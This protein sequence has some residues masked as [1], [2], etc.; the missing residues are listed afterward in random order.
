LFEQNKKIGRKL[1]TTGGGRM[2]VNNQ[3]FS[4]NEFSSEQPNLL[5]RLFKNPHFTQRDKIFAEL[6]VE[7]NWEK[8]RAIL[9]SNDARA[10]VERLAIELKKQTNLK[11]KLNTKVEQLTYNGKQFLV[12][13]QLF[14]AVV[15][16]QG[17]MLRLGDL[18][19]DQEIYKLPLELGHSITTV[20]PSLGALMFKDAELAELAG[21]TF[22]GKLTDIQQKRSV[23]GDLLITHIGLSGP[24]ALD[25][26][27]YPCGSNI[28]LCFL[29]EISEEELR[30]QINKLR[31]KQQ[32][33]RSYL[34]ILLPL[35][36]VD[37]VLTRSKI[38][39][40][41]QIANLNKSQLNVLCHI[42]YR[43]PLPS[44][45]D[46][47]YP[48]CW[49]TCGGI[50]LAEVKT[51]TL[52]SKLMPQLYFTGEMLD[53]NGLCGGYNIGFAAISA[54]IVADGITFDL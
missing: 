31:N 45:R 33:L 44:L 21:L 27:A 51:A 46:N 19:S 7:F 12:N 24:A 54:R 20:T 50:S 53:V 2:N 8:Q 36:L 9:R 38:A 43:T 30:M 25:F 47:I 3:R 42:L 26:T 39:L 17:G 40:D 28:E 15:L 49:T 22:I 1:R 52:E 16:A 13:K 5:K 32:L 48:S 35:R 18:K 37:L 11:L 10:E 29:P 6:G 23:T 14:D 4:A 41:L 34:K